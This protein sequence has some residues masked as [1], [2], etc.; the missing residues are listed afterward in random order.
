MVIFFIT[1]TNFNYYT[2]TNNYF[3][4]IM[5]KLKDKEYQWVKQFN[6]LKRFY[7]F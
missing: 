4:C 5:F 1:S 3:L 6:N 7:Y 2:S